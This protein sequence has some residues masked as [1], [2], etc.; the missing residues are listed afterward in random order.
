[1]ISVQFFDE[2]IL[3][4]LPKK[5]SIITLKKINEWLKAVLT[6]FGLLL[7]YSYKLNL[8]KGFTVYCSSFGKKKQK[9]LH[10]KNFKI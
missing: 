9:D 1:M 6:L 10:Y 8:I 2:W 3:S 4:S 5:K 7:Q